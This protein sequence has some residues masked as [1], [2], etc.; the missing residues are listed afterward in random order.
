MAT[1]LVRPQWSKVDLVDRPA[2]P[3][4]TFLITKRDEVEKSSPTASQVHADA[5]VGGD[6]KKKDKKTPPGNSPEVAKKEEGAMPE[7][8]SEEVRKSLD[9]AVLAYV[10]E[11]EAAAEAGTEPAPVGDE[12]DVTKRD[13][14]PA[15]VLALITKRDE[16]LEAVSKR[17]EEAEKVAKAERDQRVLRE[18][19]DRVAKFDVLG[20]EVE[21]VAKQFKD[22]ADKDETL[23]ESLI[24][25]LEGLSEQA[26]TSALF[27]EIG[28]AES[29][30]NSAEAA[31]ELVVKS[32][33][34]ADKVTY[35]QAYDLA[36][37]RD[38]ALFARV[39]QEA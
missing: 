9:P 28:K 5:P 18:W 12:S 4:A 37:D 14:I 27:E 17:A 29:H 19:T 24:K 15:D 34:E 13:D 38:P 30:A 31:F 23:A 2:D 33:Q 16:E 36:I 35:E 3:H 39:R 7:K 25:S 32:I 8:L 1:R 6:K 11:L 26:A 20:L 22:L 10:T 21:T